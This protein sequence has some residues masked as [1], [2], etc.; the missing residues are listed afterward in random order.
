MMLAALDTGSTFGGMGSSREA[1]VSALVEPSLLI[2][3]SRWA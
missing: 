1:M 3:L 2:V